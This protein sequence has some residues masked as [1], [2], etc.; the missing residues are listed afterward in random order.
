MNK[1]S[2]LALRFPKNVNGEPQCVAQ[3]RVDSPQERTFAPTG[4]VR[5][6]VALAWRTLAT[7]RLGDGLDRRPLPR[8][9]VLASNILRAVRS[10]AA[11]ESRRR[12]P[13]MAPSSRT[14]ALPGQSRRSNCFANGTQF[15]SI[16]EGP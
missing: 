15:S 12:L 13:Q 9:V 14:W 5:S 16:G 6:T 2:S 4:P 11:G 8:I 10:M 1:L 3:L 7:L